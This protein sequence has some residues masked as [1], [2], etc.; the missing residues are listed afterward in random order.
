LLLGDGTNIYSAATERLSELLSNHGGL[1]VNRINIDQL[2][3]ESFERAGGAFRGSKADVGW[4]IGAE[5]LGYQVVKLSPAES[6]A[7]CIAM[8]WKK[9]CFWCWKGDPACAGRTRQSNAE[10]AIS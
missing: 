8:H 10:A 6:I 5:K 7:H 1:A 2:D 9:N 4:W 3:Y